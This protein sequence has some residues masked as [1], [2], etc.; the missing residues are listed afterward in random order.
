LV[1]KIRKS[2]LL[3]SGIRTYRTKQGLTQEQ[4]TA[5]LQLLGCNISRGTYAKIEAG[6]RNID[7]SELNTILR[8]LHISYEDLLDPEE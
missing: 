2:A 5:K 8:M 3:G 7:V 1:Q 4:M 6:I